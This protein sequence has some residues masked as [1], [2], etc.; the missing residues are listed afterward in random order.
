MRASEL[1]KRLVG[2]AVTVL[3]VI[4]GTATLLELV[5]G[6]PAV[7][8]AGDYAT[9]ASIAATRVS[10]GLDKPFLSRAVHIVQRT[11]TGDLGTSTSLRPGQSVRD[12]VGQAL[13]ITMS[14]LL[15]AL[16]FAVLVGIPLGIGAALK[17]GGAIDRLVVGA[18]SVLLSIPSFV[19]GLLL[20][21]VLAVN[22]RFLPALGYVAFSTNPLD[23]ARHLVLPGITLGLVSA[24][25]LARQVRG[26]L[27]E[28][29]DQDHMRATEAS[30]VGRGSVVLR[31]G[32]KNALGPILTVTGLQVSRILG[33]AVVIEKIFSMPGLGTLAYDAVFRRDFAA[34]QGVV[35]V[36][37]LIVVLSSLVV[38]L[39]L[40]YLT[41]T[42]RL[43]T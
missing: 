42:H 32:V 38:D 14:L 12:M 24:A 37:A 43:A 22:R 31:H 9:P 28:T 30:G 17:A 8:A 27:V 35:V 1:F 7:V 6:D 33:G 29:F 26:A 15:F 40:A 21:T 11:V 41:P 3:L 19:V 25:E 4:I 36:G 20:I 23:W 10:L 18:A 2:V 16:L 39:L 5:P 13:P 34:M